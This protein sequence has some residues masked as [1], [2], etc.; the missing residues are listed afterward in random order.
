[1]DSAQAAISTPQKQTGS[2]THRI[3]IGIAIAAV[4]PVGF[5][6]YRLYQHYLS[7][8][9]LAPGEAACG[10]GAIVQFQLIFVVVPV[11]GVIGA[12]LGRITSI[13]MVE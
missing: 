1:M 8:P 4:L 3:M 6:A 10:N 2:A 7:L 9:H 11:S 5:G 12:A 13:M